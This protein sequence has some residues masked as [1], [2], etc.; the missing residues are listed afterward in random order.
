MFTLVLIKTFGFF[1]L[2]SSILLLL[3]QDALKVFKASIS[4][5]N[6]LNRGLYGLLISI[7]ILVTHHDIVWGVSI[8]VTIIGVLGMLKSVVSILYPDS[9]I[10]KLNNMTIKDFRNRIIFT[11][12]MSL[13][14]LY[15]A[16][17]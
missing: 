2:L 6:L 12:I 17:K 8:I 16:Y 4:K 15:F 11:L 3:K 5:E 13:V 9:I 10:K 7:L 14:L 1:Y